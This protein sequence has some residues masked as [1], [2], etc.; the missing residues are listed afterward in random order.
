MFSKIIHLDLRSKTYILFFYVKDDDSF[1]PRLH[2][3]NV[4]KDFHATPQIL[5]LPRF[6]QMLKIRLRFRL[7]FYI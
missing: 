4:H 1:L 6:L 2:S 5:Y 3:L 7:N